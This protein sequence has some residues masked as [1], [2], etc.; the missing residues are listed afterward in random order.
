MLKNECTEKYAEPE[1]V[2]GIKE[3]PE[4]S[5]RLCIDVVRNDSFLSLP[6]NLFSEYKCIVGELYPAQFNHP[7][8]TTKKPGYGEFR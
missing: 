5:S 7:D 3:K 8:G 6:E 1:Q 4:I 2:N